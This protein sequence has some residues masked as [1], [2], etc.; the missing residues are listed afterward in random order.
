MRYNKKIFIAGMLSACLAL[1][2]CGNKGEQKEG[3]NTAV[4]ETQSQV[5]LVTVETTE[6][7]TVED[8][9]EEVLEAGYVRSQLTNEIVTEEKGNIRPV[10][11]MCPDDTTA[12][13]HYNISKAD[14]L[15]ECRV[16]GTIS[17]FMM[18]VGDWENLERLGNVRSARE[19]YVYWAA[20][21]DPI[22]FHYGNPYYADEILAS[23]HIDRVNGTTAPSGIYFRTSERPSPQ[24]AYIST[25]GIETAIK[26]FNY[27]KEHTS[28]Y[29]EGHY[30]FAPNGKPS[31]LSDKN[32]V[33]DCTYLDLS[34]VFP[35]DKPNFTFNEEDGCYYRNQYGSAH[36]DA[37]TGEQ[38]KFSNIILQ[39][40][41]WQVLDAKGYLWF[42]TCET[43][44]G[45]YFIT[46][47]KCI[48][49]TWSK[50]D[51]ESPTKY[52]DLDGNEIE[53]STGKTMVCIVE[54][55]NCEP[56]FK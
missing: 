56:K 41:D 2:A 26:H 51:V 9:A 36:V 50:A 15:Y 47:G 28:R 21:W 46:N 32:G 11:V 23:E 1:S 17:R 43:G 19:Y 24:N 5:D 45:G 31:D 48:P 27:T 42:Q 8:S 35:V 3:K 53:L 38:L 39:K 55:G 33:F 7:V 10:A 49:I 29:Q 22:L 13:P 14:V 6:S 30:T 34:D 20:E 44:R 16:E 25:K 12:L 4:S 37:A 52:Y 40:C 54:D 18:I